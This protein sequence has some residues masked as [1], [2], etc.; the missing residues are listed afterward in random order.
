[1]SINPPV[2]RS[3]D[4]GTLKNLLLNTVKRGALVGTIA[5][6]ATA[7][8]L[9]GCGE[10]PPAP[11]GGESSSQNPAA[12]D[13]LGC[14]VSDS[15]GFDDQSFNQSSYEGMQKSVKDLGIKMKEAQSSTT[16]DFA[17][18]LAT[19]ASA[20]CNLTVTVGFLLA[21]ATATAAKD[22]TDLHYAIVD[23]SSI[24]LPNVKPIVYNTAQA[25][26]MAGYVAAGVSKTG[27]VGTF[28]GINI[29]TVTIFMDGFAQG[30]DYYN[31]KQGKDVK[32]L[33]WNAKTQQG[34]FANTFEIVQEGTK[35]TNNLIADGA[36]V[37]MPVAGPLGKG[38]GDAI[39]AANKGGKDVKLVWVDSDGFLTAPTYKEILLTSVIKTMG[40]AVETVVKEDMDGKFDPTPYIGTLENGGVGLAPFHDLDSAVS[41]DLKTQL[42]DIKKG[43]IDGSIKVESAAS[44]K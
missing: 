24:D 18:N 12:S 2:R 32:L 5:L 19:M 42:D 14:I 1:M 6:S 13:F 10:A 8:L 33:G 43:I 39:L 27:K 15:G 25:A 9:T 30:V 3:T 23:D 17:P 20:G 36:D 37:I 38:A 29:P 28:G 22:N 40:E 26:F 7:L 11:G 41:A 16:A 21:E 31:E 44:P 4:G 34:V 35:N